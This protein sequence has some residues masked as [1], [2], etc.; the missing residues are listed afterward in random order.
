MGWVGSQFIIYVDR[1]G[2]M[3]PRRRSVGHI[4]LEETCTVQIILSLPQTLSS[5]R[6]R[7]QGLDS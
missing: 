5:L 4:N 1:I 6:M 2:I 7:G 3:L